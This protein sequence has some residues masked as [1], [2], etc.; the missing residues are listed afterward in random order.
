VPAASCAILI[1]DSGS[2]AGFRQ[3]IPQILAWLDRGLSGLAARGVALKERKGCYFSAAR[4][5]ELCEDARADPA[6]FRGRGAT[7]LDEALRWAA[8]HDLAVVIT[9]GVGNV[10]VGAACA[11]GVDAACLA[12][13][14]AEAMRPRGGEPVQFRAGLWA[15][16]LV[17]LFDGTLYTEQAFSPD[18]FEP[19]KASVAVEQDTGY[20]A[21]IRNPGVDSQGN[22]S[23]AYRGPRILLAFVM[24]RPAEL[25]RAFLGALAA[26]DTFSR[27]RVLPN[28]G[29]FSGELARLSPIEI[30]PGLAPRFSG[31]A[32]ARLDARVCRTLSFR[33]AN[34]NLLQIDC[35]NPLDQATLYLTPAPPTGGADCLTMQSLPAPQERRVASRAEPAPVRDHRWTTGGSEPDSR[36]ELILRVD[37]RRGWSFPCPNQGITNVWTT[38]F[39]YRMT[40]SRLARDPRE[41]A[42]ERAI[43]M[44]S[45]PSVIDSPHRLLQFREVMDAFYRT[46]SATWSGHEQEITRLTVCKP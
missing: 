12:Q 40:A 16:P 6:G 10:G 11:D 14:L 17:A 2:M 15:V 36:L 18:R 43:A 28:L 5:L 26:A 34:P 7:T 39:D 13:A 3:A 9:D 45:A 24:A 29:G 30:F 25:G 41:L 32:T 8:R 37:C 23:Y 21:V 35:P 27:V 38:T 20:T 1:D 44:V 31:F 33:L 19:L 4:P 22:L 46:I 42:A